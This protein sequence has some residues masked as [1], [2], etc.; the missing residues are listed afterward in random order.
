M[1]VKQFFPNQSAKSSIDKRDEADP[2]FSSFA[3]PVAGHEMTAPDVKIQNPKCRHHTT[4]P[5]DCD[6][7]FARPGTAEYGC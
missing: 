5:C 2:T 4:G 3:T 6:R 7:Y 1:P